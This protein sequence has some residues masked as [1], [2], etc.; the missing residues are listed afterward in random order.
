MSV[1]NGP[2]VWKS[3][4]SV[5]SLTHLE[6]SSLGFADLSTF[7]V[8]H[9]RE[10]LRTHPDRSGHFC[11]SGQAPSSSE[12]AKAAKD[13]ETDMGRTAGGLRERCTSI[14]E[15]ETS[16]TPGIPVC[17]AA[18]GMGDS[19]VK[20]FKGGSKSHH[21]SSIASPAATVVMP[22]S[23]TLAE[24][25]VLPLPLPF[26][27]SHLPLAAPPLSSFPSSFVGH[28]CLRWPTSPQW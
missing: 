13:L 28:S 19:M 15:L 11:G 18:A 16:A 17:E 22:A 14:L 3:R 10:A 2:E 5:V 25:R 1:V 7:P 4:V 27:F 6:E 12:L 23:A 24:S 8:L 26:P 20:L 9:L 21:L